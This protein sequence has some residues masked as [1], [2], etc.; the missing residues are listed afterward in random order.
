MTEQSDLEAD[1]VARIN[2]DDPTDP[3]WWVATFSAMTPREFR[4]E[5][6]IMLSA[7]RIPPTT[8]DAVHRWVA[9]RLEVTLAAVRAEYNERMRDMLADMPETHGD[10]ARWYLG[11]LPDNFATEGVVWVYD[12]DE[13]L[14]EAR[15][16]ERIANQMSVQS[17]KNCT[18]STDYRA[19]AG[20]VYSI[21]SMDP[22]STAV[23]PPPGIA[24]RD[25]FYK[26]TPEGVVVENLSH[27]H[28]ARFRID[29]TP[30]PYDEGL[31]AQLLSKI[32]DDDQKRLLRQHF[33]S[34]L[35]GVLW[36]MQR[37]IL[38][39][40]PAATGKSTLQTIIMSMVPRN[41]ISAVPP[42]NWEH[43]Y[44]AAA[45]A[46]K[47]L[48]VVGE[49]EDRAPLGAAFKNV[50]GGGLVNARH[51]TQQPFNYVSRAAQVF[52]SNYLPPSS[53]KSEAFW[54]R[55]SVI[56]FTQ[57]IPAEDRDPA[58]ARKILKDELGCVLQ[59]AL[60]GAQDIIDASSDGRWLFAETERQASVQERWE[61][62][63]NT[64]AAFVTDEE[65][66]VRGADQMCGKKV[67][68][69]AYQKWCR[70]NNQYPMG[71]VKFR[72][73]LLVSLGKRFGISEGRNDGDVRVYIGVDILEQEF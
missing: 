41:L 4:D 40:G 49:I 6:V 43:E 44:H 29:A 39:Y 33:A 14:F 12:D 24:T 15:S 64:V 61:L 68:F 58:L 8:L 10:W 31:F 16:H 51:P 27:D 19:I 35:F 11:E 36:E 2:E 60:D 47:V 21:R 72:R 54:R 62:E 53:D 69:R 28:Y 48:N 42:Q 56:E 13:R 22:A 30:T 57:T 73:E 9:G 70:D 26:L 17:G 38:W 25:K 52:C 32:A 55:W 59:F 34:V 66:V 3:E 50:T 71:L 65:V 46:G 63:I 20:L 18:R 7:E 23:D 1:I 45:M 67:F 5:W 37:V